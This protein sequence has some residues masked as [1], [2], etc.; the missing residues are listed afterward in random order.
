M[1]SALSDMDSVPL[2]RIGSKCAYNVRSLGSTDGSLYR[3]LKRQKTQN[4]KDA[5]LDEI[6]ATNS[7]LI[8][9]L[10]SV[11][12][13]DRAHGTASCNGLTLVKLSYTGVSLSPGLKSH[14]A[15]SGFQPLVV[16]TTLLIPADYPKSSPV[17][18]DNEGD[19]QLRTKLNCISV[20]VD[21]AFR[22]ALRYLKEPRSL[23][24]TARAWDSCVRR[25][26]KEYVSR[27]GGATL[28]SNLSRCVGLVGEWTN[29][30]CTRHY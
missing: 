16:P 17:I 6:A 29:V 12:S 18:M 22:L 9:T 14:F 23:N 1:K 5:L 24:E 25:T 21:E 4:A 8:D 28:T 19:A 30:E 26:I 11:T 13:D 7:I 2:I 20:A 27:L 15:T 3:H 10:I